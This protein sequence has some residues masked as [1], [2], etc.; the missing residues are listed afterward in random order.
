MHSEAATG[1]GGQE[2]RV[3]QESHLLLE[4]GHRVTIVCPPGTPLAEHCSSLT[5]PNFKFHLVDMNRAFSLFSIW[6]LYQLIQSD[7]PDILHTHSSNDSWL[8]SICGKWMNIPSVRSRLVSIPIKNYFPRNWVYS[9]PDS[10]ITSGLA[11]QTLIREVNGV[12]PETVV[13]VDAGVDLRR[14]DYNCSAE[15]VRQE[16]KMEPGQPLIGK[17]AVIRRW[18]G[19]DI[20]LEAI[21]WVIEKYPNARFAIVGGGPGY[22]EIKEKVRNRKLDSMV[23]VLGHRED[24]PEIMAAL[25]VQVQAST[26]GEG[27]PQVIAQAFAMKTPLVGTRV[28]SIPEVF[29]EGRRGILVEPANARALSD[30]ILKL[31]HQPDLRRQ[32]VEAAYRYCL[33]NLTIDKMMDKTTA[34]YESVLNR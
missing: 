29:G 8:V 26:A 15:S 4:R 11:I 14:F 3:F 1:W 23:F 20:F 2:I 17:I 16:L 6:P 32:V 12:S 34:V 18:K 10:I 25:D 30:G 19:H 27:T 7:R 31:L 13:S 21:P 33:E 9:F 5:H 28:G 22:Q 24:I